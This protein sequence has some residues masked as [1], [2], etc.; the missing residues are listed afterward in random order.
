MHKF[1]GLFRV[2]N[3]M[4]SDPCKIS[5][6]NLQTYLLCLLET[7]LLAANY[8]AFSAVTNRLLFLLSSMEIWWW[9]CCMSYSLSKMKKRIETSLVSVKIC[10]YVEQS[11]KT[12]LRV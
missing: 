10:V 5:N 9:K 2:F 8:S 6:Q 7:V 11:E 12:V 3:L 4:F 1:T